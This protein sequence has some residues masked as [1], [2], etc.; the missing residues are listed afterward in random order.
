M[1]AFH[2]QEADLTAFQRPATA[3]GSLVSS[4]VELADGSFDQVLPALD[5]VT[6]A[7]AS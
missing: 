6:V 4:S 1:S 7:K 2:L 3:A 5:T